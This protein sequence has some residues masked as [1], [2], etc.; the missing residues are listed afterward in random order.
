MTRFLTYNDLRRMGIA[1]SRQHLARLIAANAFPQ[2]V[3]LGIGK[4]P[5][6]W[7]ADEINEFVKAKLSERKPPPTR[8][9]PAAD[10]VPRM[11]LTRPTR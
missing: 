8:P 5:R 6:A 1:P 10:I 11:I 3:R 9:R 2:P 7:L 4:G